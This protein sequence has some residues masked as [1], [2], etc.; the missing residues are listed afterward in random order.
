MRIIMMT[1]RR[2]PPTSRSMPH[3]LLQARRLPSSSHPRR[4]SAQCPSEPLFRSLSSL[5]LSFS[6]CLSLLYPPLP[7]STVGSHSCSLSLS[8][9]SIFSAWTCLPIFFFILSLSLL[10]AWSF[11]LSVFFFISTRAHSFKKQDKKIFAA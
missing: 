7:L 8:F 6:L 10:S 9:F 2:R 11:F 3:Q 5:S 1:S 4:H